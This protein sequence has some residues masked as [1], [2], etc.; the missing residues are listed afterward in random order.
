MFRTKNA[1]TIVCLYIASFDAEKYIQHINLTFHFET[2]K[3]MS[4]QQTFK[5]CKTV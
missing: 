2:M 1:F 3:Q 5:Y 4:S